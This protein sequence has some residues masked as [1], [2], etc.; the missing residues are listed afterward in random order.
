MAIQGK[1]REEITRELIFS[2][3]S[4]Y[5]V[6]KMYMPWNFSLNY[7]CKNPFVVEKHASFIIGNKF[8]EITHKAFNSPHRGD[9]IN[10][11]QDR[12]YLDYWGALKKIANDFGISSSKSIE[13]QAIISEYKQPKGI[14]PPVIIQ[15]KAKPFGEEHKKYLSEFHISPSD[16][17][18]CSDTKVVALKSWALNRAKK[19]LKINEVAF[20][21]NL[22]NERGDWLKIYRPNAKKDEKWISNIPFLEMHGLN[23]MKGCELGIITKSIK[24]GAFISKYITKC[25]CVTQAED[26]SAISEENKKFIQEN[27][28]NVYVAWDNDKKGVEACISITKETGWGYI[29]PPKELLSQGVSDMSDMGRLLGPQAVIEYFK[30]K[31]IDF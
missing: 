20:A 17:N 31:N 9:C 16:L 5:D 7:V 6:Y 26:Y 1:I 27:C 24:D 13:Y 30:S 28:K 8:G 18:F 22:K 12:F 19:G 15:A 4:S 11:V 23:N 14:K 21:Y 2:K 25:V 10:F 29:N 3:I